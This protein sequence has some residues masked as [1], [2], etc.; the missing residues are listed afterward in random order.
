MGFTIRQVG[1]KV[2]KTEEVIKLTNEFTKINVETSDDQT[3]AVLVAM[4]CES[5][6]NRVKHR[7]IVPN[8]NSHVEAIEKA[9]VQYKLKG[10]WG[11]QI[12][13]S[14]FQTNTDIDIPIDWEDCEQQF[15]KG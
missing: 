5:H 13:V 2:G 11:T 7:L 9:K 1:T 6:R 8:V 4:T 15:H 10:E 12:G 3:F 14:L